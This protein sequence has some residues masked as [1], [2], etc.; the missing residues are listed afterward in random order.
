ME[1]TQHCWIN[2]QPQYYLAWI[3]GLAYEG[4][5]H[6]L[7]PANCLTYRLHNLSQPSLQGVKSEGE[8]PEVN[9]SSCPDNSRLPGT[10]L[11]PWTSLGSLW[12]VLWLPKFFSLFLPPNKL[13]LEPFSC[14]DRF[15][16]DFPLP[17]ATRCSHSRVRC[18]RKPTPLTCSQQTGERS[19]CSHPAPNSPPHTHWSIDTLTVVGGA[20]WS[21]Y[22]FAVTGRGSSEA[23]PHMI[24]DTLPP[25]SWIAGGFIQNASIY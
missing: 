23:S 18:G 22:S 25:P 19:F 11:F 4:S 15:D 21:L 10:P 7:G 2:H 3:L 16:P 8:R 13:P 9:G 6:R 5:G 17:Q 20:Q 12:G 14:L 24:H 1:A